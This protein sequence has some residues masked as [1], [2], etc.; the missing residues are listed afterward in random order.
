MVAGRVG[1]Q[2]RWDL[3]RRC[4][5]ADG[6]GEPLP[7]RD[8]VSQAAQRSLRALG[9]ARPAHIQQHFLRGRYPGLATTMRELADAS[10]IVPV[11]IQADGHAW[12]GPWYVHADDLPL[13]DRLAA[14]QWQPRTTLL[15]PFDNLIC[16]RA[17]TEQMFDF[18]FR[19]EI[20]TPKVK[21]RWLLCPPLPTAMPI[22]GDPVSIGARPG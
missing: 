2:K 16:D 19:I 8:L 6:F 18:E 22:N 15:S 10:R 4:R 7:S 5:P 14:G 17:R 21:R 13:L 3:A 11:A 12:P 1:G 9:I 20:Y